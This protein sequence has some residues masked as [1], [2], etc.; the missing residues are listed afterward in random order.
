MD[1]FLKRCRFSFL[2]FVHRLPEFERH[3]SVLTHISP[4]PVGY[5]SRSQS[6]LTITEENLLNA[7]DLHLLPSQSLLLPHLQAHSIT[8]QEGDYP[9]RSGRPILKSHRSYRERYQRLPEA[10]DFP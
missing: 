5:F 6:L 9:D 4:V 7:K 10:D 2:H 3:H 1:R 8:R